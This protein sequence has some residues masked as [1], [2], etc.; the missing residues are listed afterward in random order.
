M[1]PTEQWLDLHGAAEVLG[2]ST[3]T[4][5]RRIADGSLPAYKAGHFIRISRT[6]IDEMIRS[7]PVLPEGTVAR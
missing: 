4:V 1:S 2:I 7:T 6:D 3:R 5:R